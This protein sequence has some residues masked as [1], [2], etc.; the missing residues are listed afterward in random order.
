[1]I[2]QKL[3]DNIRCYGTYKDSGEG[4][5]QTLEDIGF[6]TADKAQYV[7]ITGCLQPEGMP[8]VFRALKGLLDNLQIDYT[9][10]PKEY[11]CGWV[12]L[13][14][15]AVIAKNEEDI[16]KARELSREFLLENFKQAEAAGA[17][18]IVLFC[19]AC[20]PSYANCK[21]ETDLEIISY[22]ELLSRHFKGGTLDLGADYYA[23]CYR[24][25]RR[26]TTEPLDIEPAVRLL[27][28]VEGLRVNHLDNKLCCYIPPH[29]EQLTASIRNKTVITICTGCYYN[30]RDKLR[31]KGDYRVRMLP[32]VLLEAVE[33]RPAK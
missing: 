8:H 30:L 1:M 7:I 32:E 2:N 15:P 4:R 25:R 17:K 28:G 13:G 16:V 26:I 6:R 27:N 20:E 12:P 11:C 18:S 23:G 10:L 29:L 24:F 3:V 21:G 19:A 33:A 14:Q 31:G 9:L 22:S 5:R